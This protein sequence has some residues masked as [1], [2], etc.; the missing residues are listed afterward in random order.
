VTVQKA[1]VERLVTEA[2]NGRDLDVLDELCTGQLAP[3][4]R[5]A[6]S[7]FT[8]A[9]PDWHQELLELV[10][11]GDTVVARFRCHG[12]QTGPWQ[13]LPPS[14]RTM[15]IDEVYFLRFRQDR[16]RSM[17]GL[18]DTWTRFRQLAG[19]TVTLGEL[20]SLSDPLDD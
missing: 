8:A 17:W 15:K 7:S 19:E 10:A 1:I 20:G 12:T 6:F 2:M 9:F 5:Q 13:G 4:L 14:G 18:E 16:I 11:E 3:K